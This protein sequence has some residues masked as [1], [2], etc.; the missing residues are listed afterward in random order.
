MMRAGIN[1]KQW[2]DGSARGL[3]FWRGQKNLPERGTGEWAK[4]R[5]FGK[6]ARQGDGRCK[7]PGACS[8]TGS[9]S[10]GWEEGR[11]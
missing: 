4:H 2:K 10:R 3:Q 7:G 9:K 6:H 8:E 5:D 1:I 11:G